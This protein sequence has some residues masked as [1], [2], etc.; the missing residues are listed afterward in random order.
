[1]RL[2]WRKKWHKYDGKNKN[3]DPNSFVRIFFYKEKI[4]SCGCVPVLPN[5]C[6]TAEQLNLNFDAGDLPNAFGQS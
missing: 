5:I 6:L 1:V 4:S 3:P 2:E